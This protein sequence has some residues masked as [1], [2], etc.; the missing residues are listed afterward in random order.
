VQRPG[1]VRRHRGHRG[2]ATQFAPGLR[3]AAGPQRLRPDAQRTD[4]VTAADQDLLHAIPVNAPLPRPVLDGNEPVTRLY[5]AVITS[6]ERARHAA[7]VTSNQP[8]WSPLLTAES[9]RQV[10]A[11]TTVT[12]H[13]CQIL[14]RTLAARTADS[15][16]ELSDRLLRAAD[17]A[18]RARVRWLHLAQALNHVSTDT[19]RHLSPAT[20]EPADLA[21]CTGRLA[22]ADPTWTLS[23]GP[24]HQHRSPRD[25]AP[26]PADLPLAIAAA[27]HACDAMTSLACT[28]RIRTAASAYRLLVPTRSLPDTMDIPRPYAPALRDRVYT[29]LS[30]C[31]DTAEAAAH[32][33]EAAAHTAEAA[34]HTGEAAAALRA[35][36]RILAA[37]RAAANAGRVT[38][39]SPAP[40][41]PSSA[42][43]PR[44][45]TGAVQNAL[46]GLGITSPRLLQTGR[47]P[48]PRNRPAD[49]RRRR[50]TRPAPQPAHP[51]NPGHITQHPRT[52]PQHQRSRR[53]PH[54]DPLALPPASGYQHE[55][56]E[57][58]R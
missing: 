17:A 57:A 55:P 37:A 56:P 6:A 26:H 44:E 48:R 52:H 32:T 18:T 47:R 25:L 8:G 16:P 24:G 28:E 11:T 41:E 36:S 22:Y 9:L 46:H 14:L 29:L 39:P 33:A 21:L 15:T 31:Q 49:P 58:E 10:A 7:W 1:P 2:R 12:S 34:A 3:L 20:G 19:M 5:G 38:S 43:Q 13:H 53:P 45:L 40:G 35:P 42:L 54:S 30:F 51:H 50:T 4:P 23:S 27:H